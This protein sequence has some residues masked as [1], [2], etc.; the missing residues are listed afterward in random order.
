[1]T[2]YLNLVDLLCSRASLQPEQTAYIFLPDGETEAG[3]LTYQEL[4]RQARAIASQLQTK[5][6]PGDRALVIYPY[7]AGLE[8]IAAFFGCLYAGVIA[9]TCNPPRNKKAIAQLQERAVSSQVKAVLTTEDFLQQFQNALGPKLAIASQFQQLAVIATDK[10]DYSYANDWLLP[11]LNSDTIAFFQHTSGSTGIP[12]GV[13]VTHGNIIYNQQLI[14]QGFQNDEE[15]VGVGWLPMFHDMGLIGHVIQ[16]L[17]LG[18]PSILISPISLIQKPVNWLRAITRYRGTCSGGPN[19]AYDLLCLKV[20]EAQKETLDLSS[21]QL[22]YTGAE[23]VLAE[24]LERFATAFASCGFQ[25]EAFYPCYGM[26]E[27]T[28]FVSGGDRATPPIVKYVDRAALESNQVVEVNREHP[29]AKAIVGCGKT[30]LEQK[31][32]IVDPETLIPCAAERVGE[33]WVSGSGIGKGYW[34]QPQATQETFAAYLAD[35]NEGPFLR[36]GDLGFIAD[37]EL[38]ITGRLKD[39]MIFWGVYQYPHHIERTVQKSHPALRLNCGAAF[40]VEVGEKERLVI[41]QEVERN[42]L[43]KLNVEE[44]GENINIIKLIKQ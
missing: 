38:Y 36:T 25:K 14:Q 3:K 11:E 22:A 44:I 24:T 20:T 26:A 10:I 12:K 43:R 41:A 9:V 30:W 32:I 8:F 31:I 13:M 42:Y 21:W 33:I 15:T 18:I 34:N 28:L 29:K 1:M 35:T 7:H 6:E 4:D 27:A 16:P 5:L 40:A 17:Y 19:F 23:P 2:S 39:V 37:G